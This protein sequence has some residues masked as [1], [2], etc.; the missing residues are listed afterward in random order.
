[1]VE[2]RK[3]Y[4]LLI[5]I[6]ALLNMGVAV[7]EQPTI[8][9]RLSKDSIEVGD[10]VEYIIDI[11]KDRTTEIGVPI[12]GGNL[13]AKEQKE[14]AQAKLSMSTYEEYDEDIFELV[15]DYPLDTIKVEGRKLHLRKR[16]MLAV[17]ETGVIPMRPAILYFD[18]NREVPDTLYADDTLRLNVKRFME[19]D[20]TLFLKAD[21]TSEQGFG[22]DRELAQSMLKDEGIYTQKNLPFIFAE[23]KDYAIYGTIILILLGL[24]IWW[25]VWYIRNK[26]QAR[27][28]IVKPAPKLPPHVVAIK[29]L[30]EL[31]N[32]KL[33]QNGKHKLYYS[34][35]TEILR[36]YIDGR[37]DIGAL[38]MTTDEI[39]SALR[40]VEL[41][42]QSRSALI[43]IL[44]S[45]DMVKFAKATP[46]AE[47]NEQSFIDAYYF[48]ENTKIVTEEHNEDKRDI[49]FET[50]IE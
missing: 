21:P 7:A 3:I 46:D 33:W 29:A 45:A 42:H 32:R 35:L 17:M 4:T 25:L 31:K 47:E 22:V 24:L 30:D 2:S 9:A 41:P 13:T 48:V 26:W 23:I 1:M 49:S 36:V 8:S 44:R 40:D 38:E 28:R 11:E 15:E 19:L 10:W 39:I 6:V 14:E 43:A 34:S 18:K 20:T 16:Y 5:A 27:E 12:F 37:W 50:K